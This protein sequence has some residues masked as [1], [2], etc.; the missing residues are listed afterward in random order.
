MTPTPAAAGPWA[1]QPHP[2]LWAFLI[3]LGLGVA[4]LHR[5]L[6]TASARPTP[7]PRVRIARFVGALVVALLAMG[8]PLGDLAAHW[9][10]SALV[11]QRSVLVLAVASLLLSGLPDD[12]LAWVLSLIHI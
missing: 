8:W 9:S 5:R 10:L 1:W 2:F 4:L 3:T 7:W 12:V 11:L 6:I